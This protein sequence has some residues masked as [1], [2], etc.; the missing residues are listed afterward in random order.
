[1]PDPV[2]SVPPSA[3]RRDLG[4][5]AG[6]AALVTLLF[7]DVLFSGRVFFERDVGTYFIPLAEILRRLA[8][9][10][11][12]PLWNPYLAFGQPLLANPQFEVL[13]PFTWLLALLEPWTYYT[14]FVV[15]HSLFA[16]VGVYLLCRTLGLGVAPAFAGA[17][18]WV[19]SGPWLSLA[20]NW[21]HLAGAAWMPWVLLATERML[22][23]RSTRS[24]LGL[25]AIAGLQLLAGSAD[26]ALLAWL[27][28]GLRLVGPLVSDA[29]RPRRRL[30][31]ISALAAVV[32]L[33][34]AAGQWIPTTVAAAATSRGSISEANR[35]FWSVHPLF[36][37]QTLVPVPFKEMSLGP[38]AEERLFESREPFLFSLYLGLPAAA[39]V[40]A[41]AADRSAPWRRYALLCLGLGVLGALGRYTPAYHVFTLVFPPL[42]LVRY[43]MKA[44]V[45]V[46]LFW[47]VL[48]AA[49][50]ETCRRGGRGARVVVVVAGLGA[51]TLL[52]LAAVSRAGPPWLG[53]WVEPQGAE[54]IADALAPATRRLCATAALSFTL[55]AII[56]MAQSRRRL[57]LAAL[58]AGCVVVDLVAM[59]VTLNAT[60]PRQ[61]YAV[62]PASLGLLAGRPYSRVYAEDYQIPSRIPEV[63]R[64]QPRRIAALDTGAPPWVVAVAYRMY[65]YPTLLGSWGVEG[66]YDT[67]L[68]NFFPAHLGVLTGLLHTAEGQPAHTRL[69]QLGA[70]DRVLSLHTQGYE[71]LSP[72]A[73]LPSPFRGAIHVFAVPGSVPRTYV[74]A[75]ARRAEGMTAVGAILADDFRMH[76]EVVLSRE[77]LAAPP[78]SFAAD[79]RGA[80]SAG[81]QGSSRIVSWR[82]DFVRIEAEAAADGY[83]VL[84]DTYDPEWRATV[85][86]RAAPI[87]RA[88]VAFRAVAVSRGHHTVDFQYRPRSVVWGLGVA[89]LTLAG[90]LALRAGTRAATGAAP[91][92]P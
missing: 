53:G 40:A 19:S 89:A 51:V 81:E 66:S 88:N 58:A 57:P 9:E 3:R 32:A 59:H 36:L 63:E 25:G 56:A 22:R 83:L 52:A 28:S 21:L 33:G 87:V 41:A 92:S 8:R 14:G 44:M 11:T 50:L 30:A 60:A 84:V 7:H 2:D 23:S 76:D 90:L 48:A 77:P 16:A 35:T 20:S 85:D 62:Q 15:F 49:G 37:L 91:S 71:A 67:D 38:I 46:A 80:V 17:G 1:V 43:P 82:P 31:A 68:Q 54:T 12:W 47:A 70:V 45:L 74:V 75:R 4:A 61:V 42:K 78:R 13:Y 55:A 69:L 34:L 86:G 10:R 72:L 79:S 39:L 29:A 26:M 18:I 73:Q 24:A 5:L 64:A 27:A 6:L 65:P